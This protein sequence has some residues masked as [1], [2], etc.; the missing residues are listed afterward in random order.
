MSNKPQNRSLNSVRWLISAVFLSLVMLFLTPV[1][2]AA[3]AVVNAPL[4]ITAASAAG[5]TYTSSSFTVSPG[6]NVLVVFLEDRQNGTLLAEPATITWNGQTLTQD[7]N[8]QPNSSN[9]RSMAMYHLYNPPAGSGTFS[10]TYVP[11][12]GVGNNT[13][14][15]SAFTLSGVDTTTAPNILQANSAASVTSISASTTGVAAGSWAAVGSVWGTTGGTLTTTGTGGT[16]TQVVNNNIGGSEANAGYVANL[17]AG[18]VTV[19]VSVTTGNKAAFI[20]EIFAP[21][22]IPLPSTP[23]NLTA[24]A[25]SPV[26]VALKWNAGANATS[27]NLKRGTTSGIYTVTNVVAGLGTTNYLDT[28]VI[29]GTTYYYVVSATNSTGESVNSS[30]VSATPTGA[31][32]PPSGLSAT[33]TSNMQVTLKWTGSFGSTSYNVKQATTSGAE[34]TVGS[35]GGTS[36]VINGLVNGTAYYFVVSSVGVGG[37]T[38]SAEVSVV[39]S[40]IGLQD[41]NPLAITPYNVSGTALSHPF[42]VT[43]GASVMVVC[44]EDR[45]ANLAEPATLTWGSQTLTRDVQTAYNNGN[46]RSLAIYSLTNPIPGTG[47]ISGTFTATLSYW[48]VTAY[49]LNGVDTT[50]APIAASVNTGTTGGTTNLNISVS[51]IA[52]GSWAA[53]N[54]L[55]AN[56]TQPVFIN[57]T[58]A[59]SATLTGTTVSDTNVAAATFST[60][61]YVAGLGAGANIFTAYQ[62]GG[63]QKENFAIDIFSPPRLPPLFHNR[64]ARLFSPTALLVLAL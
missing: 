3:I 62:P 18:S 12:G 52:G 49:T 1:A 6:A 19:G 57:G 51:G 47:N 53:V 64:K 4:A 59:A 13:V 37:E 11:I 7:T 24:T 41:G 20:S 48:A 9:F 33:V 17:S 15:F 55:T 58:N 63:G 32:F 44:I 28:Q 5:N 46:Q 25:G 29:S 39:A 56:N 38:N 50:I 21:A 35:T 31:P 27:Y 42:T 36:Y 16:A 8:S 34:A 2:Q 45:G 54:A 40:P 23:A 26:Q 60:A 43:A 61:G 22:T 14:W 10:T 30:E